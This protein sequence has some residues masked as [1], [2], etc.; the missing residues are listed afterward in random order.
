MRGITSCSTPPAASPSRNSDNGDDFGGF[1]S[2]GGFGIPSGG[3]LVGTGFYTNA[4]AAFAGNLV[5]PTNTFFLN[6]SNNNNVGWTVG[7]GV[8]WAFALNWTA[9]IEGLYVA[10]DRE[11]TNNNGFLSAARW[12]AFPTP[13]QRLRRASLASTTVAIGRTS[14]WFGWA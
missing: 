8:E 7:G 4:A 9:K 12:S 5:G 14:A 11:R 10:F 1:G 2:F 13:A 6:D 3:S